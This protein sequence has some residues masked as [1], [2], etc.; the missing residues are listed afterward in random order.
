MRDLVVLIVGD[1]NWRAI[2]TLIHFLAGLHARKVYWIDG[3]IGDEVQEACEVY[4]IPCEEWNGFNRDRYQILVAFHDH[5][6]FSRH[7]SAWVREAHSRGLL[8]RLVTSAGVRSW[9]HPSDRS[10]TT[11][12]SAAKNSLPVRGGFAR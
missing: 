12:R 6:Q 2:D 4:Q 5:I 8:V 1:R 10:V 9:L 7:S 11:A 3:A